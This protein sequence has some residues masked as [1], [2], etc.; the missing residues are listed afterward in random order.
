M[1]VALAALR[2]SATTSTPAPLDCIDLRTCCSTVARVAA[3]VAST[4]CNSLVALDKDT[5]AATRAG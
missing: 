1:I 4:C 2:S 5:S 3:H